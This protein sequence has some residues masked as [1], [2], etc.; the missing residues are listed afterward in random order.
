M[1]P[2]TQ[3]GLANIRRAVPS[4]GHDFN[5]G[6]L[7]L[8]QPGSEDVASV[9]DMGLERLTG[10]RGNFEGYSLVVECTLDTSGAGV[11]I[12]M[13]F[14]KQVLAPPRVKA[15]L[16]Q[17]EHVAR[18]LQVYN[19]PVAALK[20]PQR[21]A[22]IENLDLISPEDKEKL[23]TW[24]QP[25][26]DAVQTSL[27]ELVESQMIKNPDALAVCARDGELTYFQLWAAADRLAKHLVSLGIGPEIFDGLCMSKSK[28]AV[29][30]ILA[31]LL[32]G[33]AVVPLGTQYSDIRIKMILD[34]A[35]IFVALAAIL[36]NT[37]PYHPSPSTAAWVVYTS[38][39]TGIP[40]GVV[41]EHQALCTGVLAQ[42]S[43]YGVTSS[44]RTL[45]FSAFTFDLSIEEIFTTLAIGRCVCVPSKT[46]RTDGLASAIREL[47]VTFAILTPT[48]AS[49]LSPE[50]VPSS[51]ET[52]VLAG[53][54][55]KPA[56]VKP[57]L[58]RIKI[59]NGYGLAECSMF[60]AIN[61]PVLCPED[62]PV[63]GSPVSNS[64]WVTSPLDHN[65]L[66]PIG[67][68][69]ELLIEGPLLA[70]EYLHDYEKTTRSFVVDPHFVHSL[71]LSP[72]RRMYRTGDLVR[73]NSNNGVLEYLGRLDTQIKIRGQHVEVGETESHIIC[74]QP[75]IRTACVD[76]V[77]RR[78]DFRVPCPS[79]FNFCIYEV[80]D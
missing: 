23:L 14:D 10:E 4:L 25:P 40:K 55:V 32:A 6:H 71:H 38:G 13:R 51:L 2:Y 18:E 3:F 65:S 74:L 12:E 78:K 7:F 49:L 68:E 17:L 72:G 42:A 76:L 15:L 77:H 56:V 5:P 69:G 41:L 27:S 1:V 59:F 60:S 52:I 70:R 26:P 20:P 16:S 64:L 19:I 11:E 30:S 33:G 28:F 22:T 54:P 80:L 66:V 24:N 58:G 67:A 36:S 45:Q 43:R 8:V 63:I 34:D 44:T 48:V 29:I 21:D 61:G 39:S 37:Q 31:V 79:S 9:E 53:A 35:G 73:Q 46:D 50:S 75:E 47:A 57:W 62:A